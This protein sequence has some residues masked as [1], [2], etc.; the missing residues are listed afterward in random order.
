VLFVL[1]ALWQRLT[2]RQHG[3]HVLSF[4]FG[5]GLTMESMLMKINGK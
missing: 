1:A 4:A 5:P 3:E 2:V